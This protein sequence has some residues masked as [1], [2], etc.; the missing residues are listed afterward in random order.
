MVTRPP[1]RPMSITC[2]AP[3]RA[4]ARTILLLAPSAESRYD[5]TLPSYQLPPG[6]MNERLV[7][8]HEACRIAPGGR[9]S[10]PQRP[11]RHSSCWYV[12]HWSF[13]LALPGVSH[14]IT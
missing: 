3:A 6:A 2:L 11:G 7:P 4:P 14:A 10:A 9:E 12:H 13:A 8:R 1:R 5:A